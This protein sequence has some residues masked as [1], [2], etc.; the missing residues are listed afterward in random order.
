M[1]NSDLEEIGRPLRGNP[2]SPSVQ[3][4]TQSVRLRRFDQAQGC[5][6]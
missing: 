5:G 4:A 1:D 3:P 2:L 6:R